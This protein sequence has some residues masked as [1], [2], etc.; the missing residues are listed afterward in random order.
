MATKTQNL[1]L[2][3][4][5]KTDFYDIGDFNSNAE[6]IDNEI[7]ELKPKV[8]GE[9][10]EGEWK[11]ATIVIPNLEFKFNTGGTYL[12]GMLANVTLDDYIEDKI[13]DAIVVSVQSPIRTYPP[14][15]TSKTRIYPVCYG[16]CKIPAVEKWTVDLIDLNN[17]QSDC[18]A[19]TVI[20]IL[21][22]PE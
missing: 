18:T 14:Y 11:R 10:I 5:D 22:K 20:D 1:G 15:L 19:F 8:I 3:K 21:Y 17:N 4:P 12:N 2:T 9:N 7:Q 6:I 16:C 13:E